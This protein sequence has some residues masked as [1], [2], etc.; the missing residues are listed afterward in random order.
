LHNVRGI[1]RS[2]KPFNFG[3]PE[4]SAARERVFDKPEMEIRLKCDIH[5][6]MTGFIFAM[7]HP[8]FAVSDASGAFTIP[9]LPAGDYTLVVW[10][11][12]YGSQEVPVSVKAG[13]ATDV[14]V[15]V[16]PAA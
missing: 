12:A 6:W 1:A 7:E 14:A 15:K 9:N 13:A 4:G 3:Q 5:S 11:E 8:F 2:N 10:H 16:K